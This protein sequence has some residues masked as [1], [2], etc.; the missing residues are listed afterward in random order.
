MDWL[1]HTACSSGIDKG[2]VILEHSSAS[3]AIICPSLSADRAKNTLLIAAKTAGVSTELLACHDKNAEG[4]TKTVNIGLR[5]ALTLGVSY[6]CLL[7]DDTNP[8]QQGWLARLIQ[9]LD[10]CPD[11]G[12]VGPSGP[13]HTRPQA[14]GK[15]GMPRGIKVVAPYNLAFFAVVIKKE[16]LDQV[17]IL[18]ERL[19]HY[20]SDNDFCVRANAKGW[21][22]VY[23]QD[24]YIKH[25]IGPRQH[26]WREHDRRVYL[27]LR[28]G[29]L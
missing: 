6:A 11:F 8:D 24:V 25:D 10:S 2:E 14:L 9:V 27:K 17:G 26:K 15:P 1:L 13:C 23:A 29:V 28:K 21:K 3:V 5:V 20:A 7:N 19:I 22:I 16:V 4:F 12:I 18:D